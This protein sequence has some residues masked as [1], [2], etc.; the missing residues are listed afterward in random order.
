MAVIIIIFTLYAVR[1]R[2]TG[3][4]F[5]RFFSSNRSA[6][7]RGRP[8]WS[9]QV[10]GGFLCEHRSAGESSVTDRHTDFGDWPHKT[11]NP[12]LNSNG[13]GRDKKTK[14]TCHFNLRPFDLSRSFTLIQMEEFQ[15]S[16]RRISSICSASFSSLHAGESISS[17]RFLH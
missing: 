13:D 3:V 6:A 11:F 14:K 5:Y 1:D 4:A 17:S 2:P 12:P 7:R 8:L 9:P 15:G 10:F 16:G